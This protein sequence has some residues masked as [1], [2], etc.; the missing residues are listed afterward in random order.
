[1]KTIVSITGGMGSVSL[2]QGVIQGD[3]SIQKLTYNNTELVFNSKEE[4]SKAIMEAYNILKSDYFEY[5]AA[6]YYEGILYY[7]SGKAEIL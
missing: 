4:A 1:M 3:Y 6:F 2:L 5:E 7:D